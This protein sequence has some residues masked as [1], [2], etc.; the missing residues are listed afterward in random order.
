VILLRNTHIN[1]HIAGGKI[2]LMI[3]IFSLI[4][5]LLCLFATL[6]TNAKFAQLKALWHSDYSYS[7]TTQQSVGRDDYYQFNA[8]ISFTLSPNANASLNADILMQTD[9]SEYTN[10]VYWNANKLST[11]GVAISRGLAIANNLDIGDKL[12]SKHNVNGEICEYFVEQI[13]PEVSSS[14][15]LVRTNYSAGIIIM[16][17]DSQ[18]VDNISHIVI[19]YTN[20]P[21]EELSKKYTAS[22]ENILYRDNEI[23]SVCKVLV[24]YVA[25]FI[26]LSV[27]NTVELVFSLTK[28]IAQNFRRLIMLGFSSKELDETY[29]IWICG[30]GYISIVIAKMISATVLYLTGPLQISTTSLILIS[31]IEFATLLIAAAFSRR[32]LWGK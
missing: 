29:Y 17:Y 10:T 30:L 26:L 15:N 31:F 8:G 4:S 12:Y 6:T 9:T 3:V 25:I 19:V 14:R 5:F 23:I 32:Q 21:I 11:F 7:A 13:L 20:D 28:C 27:L 24:P 2:L 22:P 18:Y 1:L 16:G